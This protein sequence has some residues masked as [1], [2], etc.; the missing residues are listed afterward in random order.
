MASLPQVPP[1]ASSTPVLSHDAAAPGRREPVAGA[2]APREARVVALCLGGLI[3]A[4]AVASILLPDPTPDA[5]ATA[6]RGFS[7]VLAKR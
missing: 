7:S 1:T 5:H 2:A 6:T 4:C 3:V